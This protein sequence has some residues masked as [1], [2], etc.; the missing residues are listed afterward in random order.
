MRDLTIIE[1]P[2]ATDRELVYLKR[3]LRDSWDRG[4]LPFAS[5]GF[6][7]LFLNEDNPE[8]RIDGIQAGYLMWDFARKI[9]FYRRLRYVARDG[10]RVV[11]GEDNVQRRTDHHKRNR[12]DSRWTRPSKSSPIVY[13]RSDTAP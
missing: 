6:F 10:D 8:E 5:H 2:F 13:M 7:P 1:S 3:C 9:V 11:Q 4:E 12:K